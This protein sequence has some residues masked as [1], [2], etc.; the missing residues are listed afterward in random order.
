MFFAV[1]DSTDVVKMEVFYFTSLNK[2]SPQRKSFEMMES[3]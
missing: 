3:S 1:A 2:W